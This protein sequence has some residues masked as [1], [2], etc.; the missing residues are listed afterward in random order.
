MVGI[1]GIG[2]VPEPQPERPAN[3]RER[4]RRDVRTETSERDD[5]NISSEAQEAA[6]T[7]RL[8]Q[9]ARQEPDIRAD[10]VA[11]ARQRIDNGEYKDLNVVREVAKRIL[12]LID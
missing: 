11:E 12:R 6:S 1:K 5:V 9:V 2:G 10:R 7:A 3:V 4:D 8:V